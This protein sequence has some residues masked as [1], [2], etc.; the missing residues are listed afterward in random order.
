FDRF[1]LKISGIVRVVGSGD[2]LMMQMRDISADGVFLYTDKYMLKGMRVYVDI[3]LKH[4][5]GREER[6]G[7]AGS[8]QCS[9]T[10]VRC[11]PGGFAVQFERQQLVAS[12]V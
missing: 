12:A 10:V 5:P 6:T 8:V 11:V 7:S 9:G 2:R 3:V 4:L 1:D